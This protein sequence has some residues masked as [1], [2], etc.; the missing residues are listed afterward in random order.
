MLV[1]LWDISRCLPNL[2]GYLATA[3]QIVIMPSNVAFVIARVSFVA[4][5]HEVLD[6]LWKFGV[7]E[8]W[9][10]ECWSIVIPLQ[11]SL[12]NRLML[13]D[14]L[15]NSRAESRWLSVESALSFICGFSVCKV[16][17]LDVSPLGN[18]FVEHRRIFFG[19]LPQECFA[20]QVLDFILFLHRRFKN[21][22]GS[23][24]QFYSSL[25]QFLL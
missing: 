2:V 8:Q 20:V 17:L 12:Q 14:W 23:F 3:L 16:R 6:Q 22:V 4:P 11:T 7:V 19:E 15:L 18:A 25:L 10:L 24:F 21:F 9:F 5:L 1:A 13:A